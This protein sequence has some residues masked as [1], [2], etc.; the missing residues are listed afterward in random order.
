MGPMRNTIGQYE[1]RVLIF[2]I[3]FRWVLY[4]LSLPSPLPPT[5]VS[6]SPLPYNHTGL[7][8]DKIRHNQAVLPQCCHLVTGMKNW[9]FSL[10]HRGAQT[11]TAFSPFSLGLFPLLLLATDTP[12]ITS[13][14]HFLSHKTSL[15]FPFFC[16]ETFENSSSY[17]LNTLHLCSIGLPKPTSIEAD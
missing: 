15:F 2:F 17:L 9:D 12:S 14:R 3:F 7:P 11:Q 1:Q 6:H 10:P 16:S 5:A 4:S 13:N 8:W